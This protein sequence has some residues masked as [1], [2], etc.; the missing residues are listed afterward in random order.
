[1]LSKFKIN[2]RLTAETFSYFIRR[3][4]KKD[5]IYELIF[6]KVNPG[7]QIIETQLKIDLQNEFLVNRYCECLANI[8][9]N[10][11]IGVDKQLN[12]QYKAHIDI[13]WS[14]FKKI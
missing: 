11:V 7:D 10:S 6:S 12:D 5:E 4:N 13:L 3:S 8:F 9:A 2:R 1:M 14:Y